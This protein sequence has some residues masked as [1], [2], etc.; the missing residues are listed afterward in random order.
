MN[1]DFTADDL[2]FQAEVKDFL[3][4]EFPS[5]YRKKIDARQR[6]TKEEIVDWQKILFRKGWVAPNWPKEYGGTGWSPTQKYIFS[7]EM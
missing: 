6:L 5:A 2:A 4:K 3:E 1:A 7:T